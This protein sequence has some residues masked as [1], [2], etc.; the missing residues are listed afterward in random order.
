[1]GP[2]A[3]YPGTFDPP[4]VAH[5]AVAEAARSQAGLTS[6]HLVLSVNPL[7]K[8]PVTPTLE[9]RLSVLR[10][11]AATRPW[12]EVEMTERRLI[13]DVAEGYDAVVVGLDKWLQVVDPAWYGGSRQERDA[14]V[15]ALPHVLLAHRQGATLPEPLPGNVTLLDIDEAHG[16]VSSTLVR[17]GRKEWMLPE[18]ARFDALT[19]A[20]SDPDRYRRERPR[21][22]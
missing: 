17:A 19:G 6:V 22:P 2:V 4:T 15:A 7:G 18:A 16:A 12:L 20:W 1:M 8:V 14:A 13:A 9:D 3:A 21:M 5:L 11:V 10:E